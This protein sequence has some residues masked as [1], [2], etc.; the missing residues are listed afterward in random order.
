MIWLKWKR[1]G[2]HTLPMPKRARRREAGHDFAVIVDGHSPEVDGD[3][4]YVSGEC[5]CIH[6]YHGTQAIFRTGWAVEI[7]EAFWGLIKPRSSVGRAKWIITS[8]GVI[9]PTYRGEVTIPMM[10]LG[11]DEYVVRHG[12]RMA[13]MMLLDRHDVEDIE[14]DELS[15]SERGEAGY[16]STGR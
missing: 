2:A 14:T 4:S 12:D 8:S 6:V 11:E 9:D 13:Q 7:P 5:P 10:Y 3:Y 15:P 16:G 1:M